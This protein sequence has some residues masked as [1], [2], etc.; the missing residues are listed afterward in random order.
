MVRAAQ[1][2]VLPQSEG[3]SRK[4][5]APGWP[6]SAESGTI[7]DDIERPAQEHHGEAHAHG[8]E[9]QYGECHDHLSP[10]SESFGMNDER[11]IGASGR[12]TL[13]RPGDDGQE[14]PP[15][16]LQWRV[17]ATKSLAGARVTRGEIASIAAWLEFAARPAFDKRYPSAGVS[18]L[19]NED[20]L[21]SLLRSDIV[22]KDDPKVWDPI[23]FDDH[24]GFTEGRDAWPS[25]VPGRAPGRIPRPNLIER[26][27]MASPR[28]SALVSRRPLERT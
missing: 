5:L 1:P 27:R 14:H 25:D 28:P 20:V 22:A 13:P 26:G 2:T 23:A 6:G 8:G 9:E 11:S 24:Y 10:T 16:A 18:P 15:S 4:V 3:M 17:G 21:S 7:P 12:P 19:A